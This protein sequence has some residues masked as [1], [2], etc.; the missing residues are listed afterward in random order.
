MLV[1]QRFER[2][3]FS[4]HVACDDEGCL[5]FGGFEFVQ[6]FDQ[7]VHL[8]E[9]DM[10]VHKSENSLVVDILEDKT[11]DALVGLVRRVVDDLRELSIEVQLVVIVDHELEIIIAFLLAFVLGMEIE[12]WKNTRVDDREFRVFDELQCPDLTS[13]SGNQTLGERRCQPLAS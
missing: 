1:V 9:L 4:I 8:A 7:N 12:T 6:V 11:H 3:F 13:T 10:R 5:F 2:H